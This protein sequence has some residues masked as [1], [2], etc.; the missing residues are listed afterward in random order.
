MA[1]K[2]MLRGD[3]DAE[4]CRLNGWGPGTMI[5]GN[6]CGEWTTLLITAVGE[7]A[8]LARGVRHGGKRVAWPEASWTLAY[9]EWRRVQ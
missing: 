6:E 2:P 5:R 1:P 7:N 8:I 3:S 9:R 4:T